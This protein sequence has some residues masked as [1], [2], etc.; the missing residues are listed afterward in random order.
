MKLSEFNKQIN[1]IADTA[2]EI[3]DAVKGYRGDLN[4]PDLSL[5]SVI[6]ELNTASWEIE[7]WVKELEAASA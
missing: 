6:D 7:D 3:L 4:A 1:D 2:N 5:Q